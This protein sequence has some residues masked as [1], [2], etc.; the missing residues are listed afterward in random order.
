[1]SFNTSDFTLTI[2]KQL[3]I[4]EYQVF[5]RIWLLHYKYLSPI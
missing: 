3:G 4:P 2:F 1:M 5:H